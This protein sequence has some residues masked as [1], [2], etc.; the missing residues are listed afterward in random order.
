MVALAQLWP[1]A[2]PR[3]FN[4][5]DDKLLSVGCDT[6]AGSFHKKTKAQPRGTESPENSAVEEGLIV[7]A[8]RDPTFETTVPRRTE[9]Y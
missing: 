2:T 6:E 8:L 7:A 1:P 4:S 3:E 9:A 5:M